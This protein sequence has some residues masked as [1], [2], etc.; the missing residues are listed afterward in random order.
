MFFLFQSNLAYLSVGL[1]LGTDWKVGVKLRRQILCLAA[2]LV[3]LS[4][5]QALEPLHLGRGGKSDAEVMPGSYLIGVCSLNTVEHPFLSLQEEADFAG[6]FLNPLAG[7]PRIKNLA[8]ITTLGNSS[9]DS[10]HKMEGYE[11]ILGFSPSI[12]TEKCKSM[13]L[14]SIDF[15]SQK[16]EAEDLLS[17]WLQKEQIVFWEPNRLNRLS[18]LSIP[19]F[20]LETYLQD[21][22]RWWTNSIHL[23][24]ALNEIEKLSM[25]LAEG[26]F[27]PVIAV[28][29]SGIDYQHPA[30]EKRIWQNPNSMNS[31]CL[32]D[33]WGC[34]TVG[35]N[36]TSL[37]NGEAHP[38][39]TERAGQV[40]PSRDALSSS[41]LGECL[42]GTHVAGVI[43]GDLKAG[44]AG[45]CPFCQ[46]MNIRVLEN[47]EGEGRVPGSAVLRALQ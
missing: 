36:A 39:G 29:D 22:V 33:Q 25:N 10:R 5:Q 4:C 12:K 9:S 30:L 44:V 1:W 37:G 13:T 16:E 23:L 17:G 15:Y 2:S 8:F 24:P 46:I 19:T 20:S 42:H 31:V 38:Y 45:V 14:A 41:P 43:A 27:S 11:N 21:G 28:L 18:A 7:D 40:C 47:I 32:N 6:E 3:V 35:E 34:N 26:V